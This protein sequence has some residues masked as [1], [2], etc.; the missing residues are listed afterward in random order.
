MR[1]LSFTPILL[2]FPSFLFPCL[3]WLVLTQSTAKKYF[4][5]ENPIGK[6]LKVGGTKN[7][8]V[9]GICKDAPDNSQIQFDFV[10]SFTTLSAST[11]EKYDEANYLTYLLLAENASIEK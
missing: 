1:K 10:G 11:E 7:F 8:L 3:P 6:T 4:G 9:T 2:F 5:N